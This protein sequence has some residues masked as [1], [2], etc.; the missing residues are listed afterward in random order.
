MHNENVLP[1]QH[2]A[3]TEQPLQ[4]VAVQIPFP[5]TFLYANCA[6]FAISQMEI[7]IG[8]AEAMQ[9]GKAVS[10]V[11]IVLPPEAAAV[12]ALVLLAQVTMYEAS[13]GEIRH[14]MWKAFKAGQPPE[15]DYQNRT[16]GPMPPE[17]PPKD[18]N[19]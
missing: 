13:F 8:F 2:N 18:K 17:N 3:A 12:I 11:G 15:I 6:A 19:T 5:E 1:D 9:T 14:S 4:Q 7:R 10:K 16:M